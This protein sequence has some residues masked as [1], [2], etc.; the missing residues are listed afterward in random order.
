MSEQ[1]VTFLKY[2]PL[3]NTTSVGSFNFVNDPISA[4][5]TQDTYTYRLDCNLTQKDAL[6]FRY[7]WNSTKE[8]GTPYRATT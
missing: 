4:V 5:A 7:V 1:A 2:T 8:K 3:P 6:A